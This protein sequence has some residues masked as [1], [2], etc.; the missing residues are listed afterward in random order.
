MWQNFEYF[1]KRVTPVAKESGVYLAL[2][3]DDPP[4]KKLRGL[5]RIFNTPQDF[6]RLC[7]IEPSVHNGI[8]F[9]QGKFSFSITA[10]IINFVTS[11][12]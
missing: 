8:T 10:V 7:Q 9:C 6:E 5:A 2:H 4:L 11:I 12:I 1:I 3:P